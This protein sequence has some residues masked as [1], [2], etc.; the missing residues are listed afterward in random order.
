MTRARAPFPHA[1]VALALATASAAQPATAQ[2]ARP[3]W[4]FRAELTSVLSEGNAKATT[5]GVGGLI[6]NV[7]GRNTTRFETGAIRTESAIVTRR[8]IGT[9]DAF[10]IETDTRTEKTAERYFARARLDRAVSQH[11]FAFGG[12]DWLRNT[13]A[14]IDSRFLIAAGAGN[15]WVD[16]EHVRF[17]TDYAATYTFQSD[18][19]DNPFT[20]SN[21]PGVRAG[22]EYWNRLTGSTE[23]ESILLADLNL[24]NT[25]DVR[26]DFRNSIAVAINDALALKPSLQLQW[27]NDPA[28]REVPLVSPAGQPLGSTVLVPLRKLDTTFQLALVLKL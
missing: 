28:L 11:F 19:V 17:K 16:R 14:G 18:V 6:R 12:L 9:A 24:D 3:G 21:F 27:R 22:W 23:Y 26:L 4:G 7:S 5:L 2:D 20:R 25:Q 10:T 1:A 8:A 15:T 13:F